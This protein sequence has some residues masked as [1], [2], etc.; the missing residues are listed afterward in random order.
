MSNELTYPEQ[1]K[2]VAEMAREQGCADFD[3]HWQCIEKGIN[4]RLELDIYIVNEMREAGL[5]I[6]NA[7]GREQLVFDMRGTEFVRNELLPRIKSRVSMKHLKACVHVA[8]SVTGPIKTEA[9]LKAARA[10]IQPFLFEIGVSVCEK[11]RAD[12]IPQTH[13]PYA[14]FVRHTAQL[15]V[16]L[17]EVEDECP[18]GNWDKEQIGEFLDYMRPVKEKIEL[19]EK[20]A[21]AF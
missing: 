12:R 6:N 10:A 5:A 13:D 8:N 7:S 14:T 15:S 18:M 2:A 4:E 1:A 21:S 16:I 11:P 17:K 9:D 20:L 19:A 3:S